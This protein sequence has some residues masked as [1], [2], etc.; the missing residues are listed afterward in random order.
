M[1]NKVLKHLHNSEKNVKL[2]KFFIEISTNKGDIVLDPFMGSGSTGE[3]S[4]L[5]ERD[6]IGVE[7]NQ[8]IY[9]IIEKN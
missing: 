7:L 9:K 6:F 2:L 3:A 1:T 4:K 5:C 8:E